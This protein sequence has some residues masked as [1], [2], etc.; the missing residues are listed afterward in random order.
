[1]L[2]KLIG[3][4]LT[5]LFIFNAA[6]AQTGAMDFAEYLQPS[7]TEN[8]AVFES[9]S[10]DMDEDE[11]AQELIKAAQEVRKNTIA[12]VPINILKAY[13]TSD[14][15]LEY[16]SSNG[17]YALQGT[18]FDVWHFEEINT[19]EQLLRSLNYLFFDNLEVDIEELNT[20]S[21][22]SENS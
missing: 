17:R 12:D 9:D 4:T 3:T 11:L 5:G 21:V 10:V 1:M 2:K 13:L 18:L 22:Y 19:P 16:I 15:E 7:G 14:G 8:Q 20:L 6:Q